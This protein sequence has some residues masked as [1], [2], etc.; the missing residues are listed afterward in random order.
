MVGVRSY[1]LSDITQGLQPWGIY[2]LM[3]NTA[4]IAMRAKDVDITV[5]DGLYYSSLGI[6]ISVL[7]VC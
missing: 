3:E 2:R 7:N 1:D 5:L 6:G 4:T